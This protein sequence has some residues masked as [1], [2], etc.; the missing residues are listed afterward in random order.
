MKK[1]ACGLLAVLCLLLLL[2]SPS[3]AL[4]G[5]RK[6]LLLWADVVLPT[7]LPFMICSGVI[8]AMNAVSFFVRP[9][10][11]LLSG[12]FHLSE[13]GSF[14]F[15]TGLLCGCPMG[16]KMDSDFLDSE[17]ISKEEGAYLLAICNHLSPMFILGYVMNQIHLVKTPVFCSSMLIALCLYL[18]VLPLSAIARRVYHLPQ[19]PVSRRLKVSSACTSSSSVKKCSP[20]TCAFSFEDHMMGCIETMVKIG[21]YIMLFSMVALYL[22]ALPDFIPPFLRL[23]LSAMAETTTGI[24][25][26]ASESSGFFA[27]FLIVLS[28]AFG[29]ISG[30]FQTKSVLKNAGLN[31]RHYLGWKL[32]HSFLSGICFILCWYLLIHRRTFRLF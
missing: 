10:S 21:G 13:Q 28:A 9:F 23:F 20:E 25:V 4:S 24:A 5:A 12:I 3:I 16:A 15:L 30:L 7:L 14:V 2:F 22:T 32:L 18:P 26:A 11:F 29:G 19:V 8:A 6:G 17:R 31:V 27:L 1:S